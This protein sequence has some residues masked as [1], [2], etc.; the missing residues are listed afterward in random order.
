MAREKAKELEMFE[1]MT[2]AA[3]GLL[4]APPA[5]FRTRSHSRL[6]TSWLKACSGVE[7]F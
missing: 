6:L 2:T 1:N 5:L 7:Q 3:S 4:S